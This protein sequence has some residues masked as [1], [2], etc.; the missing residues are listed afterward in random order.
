MHRSRSHPQSLEWINV[1]V[2]PV[3][4]IACVR[5]SG[6]VHELYVSES[7]EPDADPNTVLPS[8]RV[9]RLHRVSCIQAE[10][11]SPERARSDR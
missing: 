4:A 1:F 8:R 7:E 10:V 11:F 6:S 9:L 3:V 5:V 2:F